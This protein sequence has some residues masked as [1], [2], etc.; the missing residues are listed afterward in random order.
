MLMYFSYMFIVSYGF[1]C[2]T[3]TIGFTA[4]YLFVRQ[5]YS[6]VKVRIANV[7]IRLPS[8]QT[9]HLPTAARQAAF[10]RVT[11][12][13]CRSARRYHLTNLWYYNLRMYMLNAERFEF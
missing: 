3:G 13:C 5:I 4:C 6:A 7:P 2:L 12:M 1:F 11:V 8:N 10:S 9:A